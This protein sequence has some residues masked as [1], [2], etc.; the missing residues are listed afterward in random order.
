[1][2]GTSRHHR[3]SID[4]A[5]N[6]CCTC[7]ICHPAS[8]RYHRLP[9]QAFD[10]VSR[11][12]ERRAKSALARR[13]AMSCFTKDASKASA[14]CCMMPLRQASKVVKVG[15]H[16]CCRME[17]FSLKFSCKHL[18]Y[19]LPGRRQGWSRSVASLKVLVYMSAFM[20][21]ALVLS[22]SSSSGLPCTRSDQRAF[23][24][25]GTSALA[26][27]RPVKLFSSRAFLMDMFR[28]I[29]KRLERNQSLSS[30]SMKET[31]FLAYSS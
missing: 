16:F 15:R 12:M 24:A 11:R 27:E 14:C 28:S 4:G 26:M 7:K 9:N 17:P 3:N 5:A 10:C 13:S 23:C 8:L 25:S 18:R 21:L 20:A 31:S 6:I 19:V 1:M 2:T 29:A 30:D 22:D